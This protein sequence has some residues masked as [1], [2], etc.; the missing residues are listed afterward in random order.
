MD[1]QLDQYPY[2]A[3]QTSM[4]VQFLPAWANVGDNDTIV[5]RIV[6]A[7]QRRTM[8]EDIRANHAD[9]DDLGD[10]SPWNS[11]EIGNCRVN[12][13][14]QGRTVG[15]LA[16]EAGKNPIETVLDI[17][18]AERNFVSAVNFAICEEDIETVMKHSLTMIGSDA[19]GTAPRG[20]MAEDRVHP[21]SYGTFPRVLGRYVR[22]QA[23]LTE[24]EAVK[25]MT[26]MPA[27][28]IGLRDR[29]RIAVGQ[30]ADV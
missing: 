20:S 1:V 16:R 7:D 6:D 23:V 8:L 14:C 30:Y 29:G 2:T 21:R 26:S 13:Q 11:V 24:A 27:D 19:V 15:D 18:V 25:K 12:R 9:W 5:S 10:Y 28:R 4:S 17:I 22:E 3:F